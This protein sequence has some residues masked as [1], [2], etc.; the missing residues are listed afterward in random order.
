MDHLQKKH[1][2][3]G[4]IGGHLPILYHVSPSLFIIFTASHPLTESISKTYIH[5]TFYINKDLFQ[6][7][8]HFVE[9]RNDASAASFK[10]FNS[11]MSSYRIN[12]KKT[13][14]SNAGSNLVWTGLL[15]F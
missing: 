6:Y 7:K 10:I 9:T 1:H 13:L 8:Y 2:F 12:N 5:N 15:H 4:P 11:N 14:Y 3:S